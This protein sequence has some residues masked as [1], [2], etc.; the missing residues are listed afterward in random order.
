LIRAIQKKSW[1]IF[2]AS[3]MAHNNKSNEKEYFDIGD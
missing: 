1:K 2:N 3:F